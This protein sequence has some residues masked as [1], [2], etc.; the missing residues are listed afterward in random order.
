MQRKRNFVHPKLLAFV[1]LARLKFLL[2]GFTGGALGTAIAAYETR[3]I[4]V[5]AYV[6]AQ[7]AITGAHLMTQFANEFYDRESDALTTRT[8]YSGGSGVLVAGELAP[9]VAL[10]AALACLAV[11]GCGILALLATGHALAG[12]IGVAIVAC[13]WAY[14][15]PPI[16]LL[17]RGLGELD[18]VLVVAILVPL[19]SYAAQRHA[20]DVRALASTLPGAVAMFVMMLCVELPDVAADAATGK[21]NLVVRLGDRGTSRLA[22]A[23][24]AVFFLALVLAALSA[25]PQAFVIL[26][27]LASIQIYWL[28]RRFFAANAT[29]PIAARTLAARGV[30]F[31]AS[32]SIAGALGYGIALVR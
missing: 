10:R 9:V 18:T 27:A 8:P 1:R 11:S 22:R 25:T 6:L 14:S 5:V 12:C 26:E 19:C 20:I 30:V 16:R 13:A 31:F 24:V 7:L 2:G 3:S 29:A 15:A 32:V 4:D 23:A 17:A 21:R 28:A